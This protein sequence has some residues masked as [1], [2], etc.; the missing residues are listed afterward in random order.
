MNPRWLEE[1]LTSLAIFRLQRLALH[2]QGDTECPTPVRRASLVRLVCRTASVIGRVIRAR[3]I[4]ARIIR[5]RVAENPG[6]GLDAIFPAPLRAIWFGVDSLTLRVVRFGAGRSGVGS[7]TSH[8]FP[9]VCCGNLGS[10]RLASSSSSLFLPLARIFLACF[11]RF[12]ALFV[13]SCS[14]AAMVGR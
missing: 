3:I 8:L 9:Q 7:L 2:I 5:Y 11:L 6:I 14:C 4:R 13:P 10:L 1:S 12:L